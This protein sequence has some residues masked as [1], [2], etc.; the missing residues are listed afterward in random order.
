MEFIKH[1][2][3]LKIRVSYDQDDY[4]FRDFIESEGLERI[5][6]GRNYEYI[7]IGN[8]EAMHYTASELK[9]DE[10][11]IEE[12]LLLRHVIGNEFMPA[13]T[14]EEGEELFDQV[15]DEDWDSVNFDTARRGLLSVSHLDW[16]A[17]ISFWD[18]ISAE[19]RPYRYTARGYCQGDVAY[20]Y[21]IGMDEHEAERLTKAFAQY[22][23]DCPYR[24]GVELIDCEDGKTIADDSC[25][26]IYD[27]SCDL[28]YLK[29][30]LS[31]AIKC[32]GRI[33][34]E[35]K[36]LALLQVQALDYT[37]IDN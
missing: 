1:N 23:Y 30:E 18:D 9:R 2:Q 17:G 33:D 12:L 10:R 20:L 36:V 5:N 8:P 37:S 16:Y 11:V 13:L 35:L 31:L 26:G 28:D 6:D 14:Q 24:Y 34:E 22:A 7:K 29:H 25:G 27:T 3:L 15:H 21:L 4:Y 32:L 19:L